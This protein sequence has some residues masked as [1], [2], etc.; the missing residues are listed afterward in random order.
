MD[1][2]REN[3]LLWSPEEIPQ[4][5]PWLVENSS[6]VPVDVQPGK[7]GLGAVTLC[8]QVSLL[9]ES[10]CPVEFEVVRSDGESAKEGV[11]RTESP[12]EESSRGVHGLES[13]EGPENGWNGESKPESSTFSGEEEENGDGLEARVYVLQ[14]KDG[15]QDGVHELI[16]ASYSLTRTALKKT[17]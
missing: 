3:R 5:S 9:S 8:S 6:V 7:G 11:T 2:V 14:T 15:E 1:S 10:C 12:G 4:E 13:G 17:I 16:H